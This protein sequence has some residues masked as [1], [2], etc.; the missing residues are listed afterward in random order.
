MALFGGLALIAPMLI[1]RLHSTLITQLVTTS[2]FVLAVGIVLA[3]YMRDADKK[4]IL[5]STAA[6]AAVLVVFVGTGG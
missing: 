1:M 4:D 6:Y 5:A 3:W 2:V